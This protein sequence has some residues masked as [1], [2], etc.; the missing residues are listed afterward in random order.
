MKMNPVINKN[1]LELKKIENI[2]KIQKQQIKTKFDK[3][4]AH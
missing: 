3:Y 4:Y 2:K 1:K